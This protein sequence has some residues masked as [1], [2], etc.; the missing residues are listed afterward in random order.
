MAPRTTKILHDERTKEKI[1]ASQL[2]NRLRDHAMGKVRMS[3]T[4]VRAA[5][6]LLRKLIPDLASVEYTGD[7]VVRNVVVP[8]PITPVEWNERFVRPTAH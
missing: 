7:M 3:S 4:Q 8:D 6:I 5:E 2:I 1:R